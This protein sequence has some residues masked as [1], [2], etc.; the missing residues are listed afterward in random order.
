MVLTLGLVACSGDSHL[1]IAAENTRT[2][3]HYAQFRDPQQNR[4]VIFV[5]DEETSAIEIK[6]HAQGLAPADGRLL[7][8]YYFPAGGVSVPPTRLSRAGGIIRAHDL[9]YDDPE[10]GPWHYVFLHPFAGEPRF[11]D[12]LKAPEDVL[13]RQQ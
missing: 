9:M 5:F 7:A 1:E 10:I 3:T 11:T 8:A 6:Q 4:V 12:C 2:I 13:C